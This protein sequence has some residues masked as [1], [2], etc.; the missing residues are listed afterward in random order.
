MFKL[1]HCEH[2]LMQKTKSGC[3]ICRKC[4]CH[5]NEHAHDSNDE[6]NERY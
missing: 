3:P 4:I 1:Y 2:I 5:S 6:C